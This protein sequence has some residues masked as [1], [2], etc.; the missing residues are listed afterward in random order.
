M[1][2]DDR[3]VAPPGADDVR[4]HLDG[5]LVRPV[6]GVV[7]V[8]RHEGEPGAAR[9]HARQPL[10]DAAGEGQA[11]LGAAHPPVEDVAEEHERAP[12]RQVVEEGL[13]ARRQ[14][15]IVLAQVD[16]ADD[17]HG[18]AHR[19]QVHDGRHQGGRHDASPS[20]HAAFRRSRS[21]FVTTDTLESAMAAAA[22]MG[23]SRPAAARGMP[24]VL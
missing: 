10:Q 23:W 20:G 22:S 17:G 11:R 5:Q 3:L 7:P 13:E 4:P 21:E 24:S 2:Q 1:A 15:G 18:R 19:L 16:V 9:G 14:A 12:R 8:A 6:E